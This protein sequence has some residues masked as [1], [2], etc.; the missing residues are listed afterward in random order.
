MVTTHV[1]RVFGHFTPVPGHFG[2][3]GQTAPYCIYDNLSSISVKFS[4][5]LVKIRAKLFSRT[6]FVDSHQVQAT[7]VKMALLAK[8]RHTSYLII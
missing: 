7:L 8:R 4:L 1:S 3:V 6:F 5:F 2:P